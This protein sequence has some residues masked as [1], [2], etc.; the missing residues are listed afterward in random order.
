MAI[1]RLSFPKYL[2]LAHGIQLGNITDTKDRVMQ[3]VARYRL[4]V[5]V[6]PEG[7]YNLTPE[8]WTT[9]KHDHLLLVH[10]DGTGTYIQVPKSDATGSV[11]L[12]SIG[13]TMFLDLKFGSRFIQIPGE[14]PIGVIAGGS[15]CR[16]G[17]RLYE[18]FYH[19]PGRSPLEEI[20]GSQV[21]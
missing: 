3:V 2:G 13:S 14:M 11:R 12:E 1:E 5:H 21:R 16:R 19:T 6:L 15:S 7:E 17:I 10:A 18:V 9:N 4:Q 8:V 20:I